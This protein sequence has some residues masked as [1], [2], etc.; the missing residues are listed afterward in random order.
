LIA[1]GVP[2][3]PCCDGGAPPLA[4]VPHGLLHQIPFHAL[5]DGRRYLLERFEIVRASSAAVLARC[6]DRAPRSSG[7]ALVLGVSDPLL[8]AVTAEVGSVAS[9]LPDAEVYLDEQATLGVLTVRASACALL[10]LACHG[11]FRADNPMFSALKLHDG[12]L[13]AADVARMDLSGA[14]VTL[15]ACESGRSQVIAGDEILGLTRAFL[16]AGA[17]TLVV[18]LWIV[19]DEAAATLMAAWYARLGEGLCPAAALR[20]AQLALKADY[21]HPYYWAPFVLVG[22]R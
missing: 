17:A 16:V 7:T 21:P 22:R 8:P 5:F 1:E 13:T 19:Q 6:Q 18:S 4:I 11:L 20:A 10:H 3:R 14:L 12:W 15:S 9:A 2:A